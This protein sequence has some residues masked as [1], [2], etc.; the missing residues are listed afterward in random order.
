[1][2]RIDNHRPHNLPDRPRPESAKEKSS[3]SFDDFLVGG[4]EDEAEGSTSGKGPGSS[5]GF[6][7][8]PV[9]SKSLSHGL[10]AGS[11]G[12][13]AGLGSG[14]DLDLALGS[15][16]AE[17]VSTR[18]ES[19]RSTSSSANPASAASPAEADSR[20]GAREADRVED[21]SKDSDSSAAAAES[22]KNVQKPESA[23]APSKNGNAI[24]P[25]DLK[26]VM[27]KMVEAF[28]V[29]QNRTGATE[30][31]MDLKGS[32]MGGMG[33]KMSSGP[34]GLEAVF[35]VGQYATK[36]ALEAQMGDLVRR[37]E[38]Q[39]LKVNEVRVEVQDAEA[40]RNSGGGAQ[41]EGQSNPDEDPHADPYADPLADPAQDP[42]YDP[43]S[44]RYA[45][46]DPTAGNSSNRNPSGPA[47]SRSR[48]SRTDYSL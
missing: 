18:A 20:N 26:T 47:G 24:P 39:G 7:R 16:A 37:L 31:Q 17:E 45:G 33:V 32:V 25:H 10:S 8:G 3:K 34:M 19:H 35:E 44:G 41:G 43:R 21:S 42:Y 6:A 15:R 36:A 22:A 27:S 14:S 13:P 2:T 38:S 11:S 29:G 9:G 28:R 40:F 23:Q 4:E 1:M 12:S 5:P 30:V 48:G 46:T